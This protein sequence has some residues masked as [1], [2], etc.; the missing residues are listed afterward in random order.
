VNAV[1]DPEEYDSLAFVK[2]TKWTDLV[3][4]L[5]PARDVAAQA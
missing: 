5:D 2:A 4:A 1:V 3:N